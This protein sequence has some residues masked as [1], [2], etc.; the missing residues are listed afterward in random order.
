[1]VALGEFNEGLQKI[2]TAIVCS[3]V[4][5]VHRLTPFLSCSVFQ[6]TG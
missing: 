6:W 1:L 5:R 3:R 2:L 4:I